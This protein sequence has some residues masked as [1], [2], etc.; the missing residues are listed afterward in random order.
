MRRAVALCSVGAG[1][2]LIV[3]TFASSAFL[4]THDGEVIIQRFRGVTTPQGFARFH[5][6]VAETAAG[7]DQLVGK[8]YPTFAHAYGMTTPQFES[9]VKSNFSD[10]SRGVDTVHALPTLVDPVAN[11]VAGLPHGFAPVY[12]LP[13][14]GLP[15]TSVPWI[16][17][18]VGGVLVILG[19][20]IWR[21][22]SRLLTVAAVAAGIGMI[23]VPFAINLPSKVSDTAKMLK[24][25]DFGLSPTAA[26]RSEQAAYYTDAMVRQTNVEMFP[27]VAARLHISPADLKGRLKIEAPALAKFL[28]DWPAI[29]PGTYGFAAE[30]RESVSQYTQARQFP[31]EETPWLVIALG[32]LLFLVA[33]GA[34]LPGARLGKAVP[35][36]EAA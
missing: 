34:L 6:T 26:T 31:F 22:P 4:R 20:A 19:A 30:I 23:V 1:L 12:A 2:A 16:L 17:L 25:A 27:A 13:I 15:L 3:F 33:A 10:V 5:A 28:G 32:G 18:V 7:V 9:Y 24:V 36:R 14:S 8:A 21:F 29:A 11:G 35:S